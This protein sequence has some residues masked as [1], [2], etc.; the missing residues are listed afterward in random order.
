MGEWGDALFTMYQGSL[1]IELRIYG[2]C[3]H[4]MHLAIC[5]PY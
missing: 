5:L 1:G 3:D 2:I 4:D